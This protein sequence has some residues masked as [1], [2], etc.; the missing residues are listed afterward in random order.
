MR[1]H[2]EEAARYAGLKRALVA[3][4]TPARDYSRA[5]TALVQELTDRARAERGLPPEPGWE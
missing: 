4:G 2:P 5:K 1:A 3:A